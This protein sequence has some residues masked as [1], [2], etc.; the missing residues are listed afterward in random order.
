MRLTGTIRDVS[1][2]FLD[3]EC[4]LTL[5]VNEKNDLKLAYDELSQ[6]K[7]LDIELKKH[8]KKRSLNANAYLWVLCGKLADKIGVDKESV[9]RQH[10]L[11]ANV[12]R[13]AE[14]NE[15]AADTLIKGWQMNGVG[16]IAERVDESNKDGFVIVNLYYGSSTYNTKQM[17]RLLDSVIEDCREQGIQTI[18][19]DEISKLKSLWE[20]EKING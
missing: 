9:Y 10:I 19:P 1:M 3:G 18:T 7:L 13:V 17:S 11:N 15:S 5:A 12:Y 16:W 2:G 6:C 14:I 20:A 4:K 8:R